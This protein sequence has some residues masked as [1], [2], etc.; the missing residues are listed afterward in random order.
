MPV[1]VYNEFGQDIVNIFVVTVYV[2][3]HH[4]LL[5]AV[6]F[7]FCGRVIYL[8]NHCHWIFMLQFLTYVNNAF[9]NILYNFKYLFIF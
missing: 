8:S 7:S 1:C 2:D 3:L 4:P 5:M 9:M 6:R